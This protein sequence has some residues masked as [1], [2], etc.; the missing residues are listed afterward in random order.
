MLGKSFS[1]ET[2]KRFVKKP[3]IYPV[4]GTGKRIRERP[5]EEPCP[6]F[7]S[8]E[9]E[10]LALLEQM[11]ASNLLD[12]YYADEC[13][14]SLDPVVPYARQFKGEDV[15]TPTSRGPGLNCLGLIRRNSASLF[16]VSVPTRSNF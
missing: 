9:V 11:S 8:L 6:E 14:V 4:R 13:R 2:L 3:P 7:C 1:E 15:W 10:G 12:L 16:E 5:L